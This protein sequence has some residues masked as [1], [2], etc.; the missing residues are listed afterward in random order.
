MWKIFL[1]FQERQDVP[2]VSWK[3][4]KP[5]DWSVFPLTFL[6]CNKQG[7]VWCWHMLWYLIPFIH[8][9]F[10]EC[11]LAS[12]SETQRLSKTP[13]YFSEAFRTTLNALSRSHGNLA[14]WL[15]WSDLWMLP[16]FWVS[17]NT[18]LK[19][20]RIDTEGPHLWL[21]LLRWLW[22][23]ENCCKSVDY[24]QKLPT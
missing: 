22:L 3:Q 14:F 10:A 7:E 20:V 5:S 12:V 17:K 15:L 21:S 6:T 8:F 24:I 16:S 2:S 23:A 1:L 9:V 11:L 13:K 4:F 18:S 19:C